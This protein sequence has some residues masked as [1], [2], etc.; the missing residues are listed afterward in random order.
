MA[1]SPRSTFLKFAVL[2]FGIMPLWAEAAATNQ[3]IMR[4][5]ESTSA[6][7]CALVHAL[8]SP[9]IKSPADSII[10]Y[11]LHNRGGAITDAIIVDGDTIPMMILDEVLFV[12]RPT[13]GSTEARRR[14]YILKRKVLRVSPWAVLAATNLDTLNARL[15]RIP[16]KRKRKRYIKEFQ[17]YLEKEFE[18]DLRKLT[19][20]EGQILC[21]LIY[22][23]TGVTA[24]QL[25]KDYRS[26][27]KAFWYNV[28]ASL[29][30]IS[31]KKTYDPQ[32]NEEDELIENILL[33]AFQQGLLKERN[34]S[35][36]T[37]SNR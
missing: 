17:D 12:P 2:L 26:N 32:Q 5:L 10:D 13:F 34:S 4:P 36:L 1:H 35:A 24:Y 37:R 29:Y 31:L 18:P 33:R 6:L 16:K 20:S 7:R 30:D 25:V 15:E 19:R 14:Y 28:A 3:G 9:E 8:D 21:K 22:R 27:W 11:V 23:E